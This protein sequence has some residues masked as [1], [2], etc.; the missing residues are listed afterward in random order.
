MNENMGWL[1]P[2]GYVLNVAAAERITMSPIIILEQRGV[3]DGG[4]NEKV[5]KR[6]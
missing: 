3:G 2:G 5:S 6:K 4:N 1:R